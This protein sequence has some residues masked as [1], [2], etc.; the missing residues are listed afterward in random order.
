MK[1][2]KAV[3]EM[4]HVAWIEL[5]A[6]KKGFPTTA[7]VLTLAF[8]QLGVEKLGAEALAAA[9]SDELKGG[10]YPAVRTKNGELILLTY[11]RETLQRHFG[12]FD[13]PGTVNVP[14]PAEDIEE[15][16]H[17]FFNG[18]T[19]SMKGYGGLLHALVPDTSLYFLSFALEGLSSCS[20]TRDRESR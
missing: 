16:L 3:V 15:F 8:R 12:L 10:D 17:G 19:L 9:Y 1:L 20:T 11:R 7:S 2:S 6:H 14:F 5:E 18:H 4:E 13:S